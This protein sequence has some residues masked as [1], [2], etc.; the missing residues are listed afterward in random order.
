MARN[1]TGKVCVVDV[2]LA[3]VVALVVVAVQMNNEI[4]VSER[5]GE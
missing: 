3:L 1:L 5:A 2:A 4:K